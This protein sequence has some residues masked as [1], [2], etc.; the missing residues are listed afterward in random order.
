MNGK[1]IIVLTAFALAGCGGLVG[2]NRMPDEMAVVAGP[3]L[4]VPPHFELRP[5]S[6][7]KQSEADVL[8]SKDSSAQAQKILT[9]SATK[10]A[11]GA[12]T[13]LVK[14]AGTDKA[15]PAIRDVLD[16]EA[17]PAEDDGFLGMFGG[18]KDSK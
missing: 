4:T 10:H 6:E 2:N 9:G 16:D 8:R 3:P 11:S 17:K 12:D 18:N 1:I 14:Q 15:D 5:P 7:Q 13:W